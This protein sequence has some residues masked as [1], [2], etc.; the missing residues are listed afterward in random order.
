MRGLLRIGAS[1]LGTFGAVV[2]AA[3]TGLGWWA[4]ART[5]DR[6][7]LVAARLEHGLSEADARLERVEERLAAVREALDETRGR[8]NGWRPGGCAIRPGVRPA[9][10]PL[11][12]QVAVRQALAR[13]LPRTPPQPRAPALRARH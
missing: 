1:A 10:E 9:G 13:P 12:L 5:A 6:V 4:A 8:S 7:T 2:C 3:A 11:P